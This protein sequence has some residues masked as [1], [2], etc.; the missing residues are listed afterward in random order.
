MT[1]SAGISKA[2]PTDPPRRKYRGIDPD[3]F[4]PDVEGRSAGVSQV[5]RRIDLNEIVI[6]SFADIASPRRNDTRGDGA[7][8]PKRVSNDQHPVA[9]TRHFSGKSH[10]GKVG[11][12]AHLDECQ[13]R[14]WIGADDLGLVGFAAVDRNLEALSV[15]DKVIVCNDI[16]VSR[17]EESGS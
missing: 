7:A 13:I 15:G 12:C 2:T 1:I 16:T 14:L 17:D 4:A 3:H 11:A 8:K 10:I 5:N 9:D 6:R